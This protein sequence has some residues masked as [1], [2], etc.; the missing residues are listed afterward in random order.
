MNF[1]LYTISKKGFFNRTYEIYKEENLLFTAK[2][3]FFLKGYYI[4]TLLGH[5]ALEIERP[6]AFFKSEFILKKGD[7]EVARMTRK[8]NMLK[9]NL[10]IITPHDEYSVV[11]N[12]WST[13]FTIHKNQCEI[14][15]ISRKVFR[16][17][18]RYGIAILEGEDDLL[19]ISV[20]LI[21]ELIQRIK[22]S[23]G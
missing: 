22:S 4:Y 17:Q 3:K 10:D 9:E 15:K 23:K 2:P 13:D 20:A 12:M 19:I 1:N 18:K 8:F 14:A 16:F 21:I 5:E 7:R 6:F 11:G